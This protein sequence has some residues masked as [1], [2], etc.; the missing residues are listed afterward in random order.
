MNQ[1]SV[2]RAMA[3]WRSVVAT[4]LL[5]GAFD[6]VFAVGFWFLRGVPP[7]RILQS[8][9]TG[10]F[11]ADAFALG[12]LSAWIGLA[13]HFAIAVV[14]AACCALLLA[15]ARVRDWNRIAAGLA[16]GAAVFAVMNFAVPLVSRASAPS[17]ADPGW[18]VPNFAVHLAIGLACV[19]LLR[20]RQGSGAGDGGARATPLDPGSA[21][22]P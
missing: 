10:W 15:H 13:S 1:P 8:I 20:P 19:L 18:T 11:G 16:Y 7:V 5:V 6:L 14:I 3:S 9:A 2:L 21:L 22:P 4:G 17:F 12:S